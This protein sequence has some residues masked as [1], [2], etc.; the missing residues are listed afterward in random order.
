MSADMP[1]PHS[2]APKRVVLALGTRPEATKM[3]PVY[4]GLSDWPGIRPLVL[5]TGQHREQLADGLRIFGIAADANLDV[6]AERQSLPGLAARILPAT[7]AALRELGADYVLVHGDTLTTFA[8]AWTAFLLGIPVGH[9]EAGLRSHR[10]DEPFPEEANRRLTDVLTDLDLAPTPGAR[11]NLLREGKPAG[12]VLVTGQTAVDAV[13]IA[14][15][16]GQLPPALKELRG[17]VVT[18]TLHRRESWPI[19]GPLAEMLGDVARRHPDDTYVYPVHLNPVVRE[20]VMPALGSVPNV[21]LFDPLDYG[22]MAALLQRSELIITDSGGLQEEGAA[23]GV[24]VIVLRNVTE[25]PE[26]LQAGGLRLA[27]TEP[28]SARACIEEVLD[29]PSVRQRMAAASNPY[30]DGQAGRRV[31]HAVAW[32]LALADRPEEWIPARSIDSTGTLAR[33]VS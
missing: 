16:R 23:L 21:M 13:R 28:N 11:E 4:S 25:R 31:A 30:G 18:I 20:A 17:R 10:L 1:T 14:A 32:R 19:L 29:S 22:A 5:A 26:G 33:A 27:G 24:P 12:R 3:A 2:G 9:V 15:S 7:A 6:M 8:V